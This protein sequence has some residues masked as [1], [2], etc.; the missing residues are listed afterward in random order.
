LIPFEDLRRVN[1]TFEPDF[2]E[3]FSEVVASGRYVLDA[4]GAAF[5]A[6]FASFL[7]CGHAVGTN[8]GFDALV[9]A[10]TA[11][12]LGE[13]EAIV[14]ASGCPA[15]TLA[16]I[17]AGLV[18]VPA[19]A[20]PETF[21][22][23]PEDAGRR[24][25]PRTVA[26]VPV[27]LYG[28]PCDMDAILRLARRHGL[29]VVEDCAQAHGTTFRGRCVGTFGDAGAFSFYP[30]K[31]LGALGDGGAVATGDGE[32]AER[33]RGLR[34]YGSRGAGK[35]GGA[36]TAGLNSRLDELQAA[37]L[38]KKLPRL[39]EI[40]GRKNLHAARYD[41]SLP[42]SLRRP[43]PHAEAGAARHLYPVLHPRR[44]DLRRFLAEEGIGTSVHYPATALSLLGN[45]PGRG[46]CPVAEEIAASTVSLPLSF[47]HTEQEIDRVAEAVGRFV[48]SEGPA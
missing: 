42:P 17:R 14:P 9:L 6:E 37:F 18:P 45:S 22:L 4:Q 26:I 8:S 36:A 2:R 47:G 11:L 43:V 39:D 30:T 27:H 44:D 24:I 16:V 7:G 5:E 23:D 10:L 48:E 3:A 1:R 28:L 40:N 21:L 25:G 33:L 19:D 35:G 15:T 34:V 12:G 32:V 20:S 31:N 46:A 38:R 13:G 41:R 29:K